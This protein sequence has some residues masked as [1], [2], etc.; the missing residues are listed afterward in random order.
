MNPVSPSLWDQLTSDDLIYVE[1][2]PVSDFAHH[3]SLVT[4]TVGWKK[5]KKH[6]V[7]SHQG[8]NKLFNS[9]C[10]IPVEENEGFLHCSRPPEKDT[11]HTLTAQDLARWRI[12][13]RKQ[14]ESS[15]AFPCL[16]VLWFGKMDGAKP[17]NYSIFCCFLFFFLQRGNWLP[18]C[19]AVHFGESNATLKQKFF[20]LTLSSPHFN[21]TSEKIT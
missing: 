9:C 11:T 8:I 20:F 10:G 14:K 19:V 12:V 5:G 1:R 16:E 13:R 15:P 4:T 18:S 6:K 3:H 17:W 21:I 2:Q 7:S